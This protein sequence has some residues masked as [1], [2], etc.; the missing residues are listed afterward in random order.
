MSPRRTALLSRA[1]EPAV[2]PTRSKPASTKRILGASLAAT[3]LVVLPGRGPARADEPAPE[4]ET[5]VLDVS[6]LVA[7][8]VSFR[9]DRGPFPSRS[10]EVNDERQPLFGRE[11]DDGE[12]PFGAVADLA[13]L[14]RAATGGPG[15]WEDAGTEL[16][17]RDATRLVVRGPR[18]LL[19]DVARF[20]DGLRA[21]AFDTFAVDV[22]VLAGDPAGLDDAA[23]T[24]RI[25]LDLAPR[26]FA[27]TTVLAGGTGVAFDGRQ[28]AYVQ[29]YDVEVAEGAMIGDPIVGVMSTGL[30]VEARVVRTGAALRLDV[31]AWW[32]RPAGGRTATPPESQRIDLVAVEGVRA[33]A[34]LDVEPGRWAVL[35]SRGEAGAGVVFAV[36]V[37]P[38]TYDGGAAR[39]PLTIVAEEAEPFGAL[40]F[41]PYDVADLAWAPP[42]RRGVDACVVP[43]NYTP[44]SPPALPEPATRFGL[45]GLASLLRS[46]PARAYFEAAEGASIELR[47][48]YLFVRADER[49]HAAIAATLAAIRAATAAT[50]RVRAVTI[51]VP[52][53]A[54][55]ELFTGLDAVAADGGA[56]LLARPGARVLDRVALRLTDGQ[57]DAVDAGRLDAVIADYDVEIASKATIGNPIVQSVFSGTTLDVTA[58]PSAGAVLLD[59]RYT[60]SALAGIAKAPTTVG[61]VDLPTLRLVKHRGSLVMR[62]GTTRVLSV[63]LEGGDVV[64]TLVAATRE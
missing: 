52:V 8:R 3:L 37:I 36:R 61:E 22:A 50:T 25:G 55:P 38:T 42:N 32:A 58:T 17:T 29:D 33:A 26:A 44:P 43:S 4:V 53:G 46:G 21:R 41:E 27:R 9:R 63:G 45:E 35:P 1:P 57:R 2:N 30:C 12:R 62:S 18:P 16:R 14:V 10:D 49:R 15:A 31:D 40:R 7:P 6:A 48:P 51:A 5:R 24:R 56:A 23:L 28:T 20:L 54:L 60:R 11:L 34:S 59:V 19:D 64:V 13:E 47:G 39:R